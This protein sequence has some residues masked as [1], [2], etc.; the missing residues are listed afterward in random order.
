MHCLFR[1]G[2]GTP[3][4][5]RH[6][7][8]IHRFALRLDKLCDPE[9]FKDALQILP[10]PRAD[11]GAPDPLLAEENI[12]LFPLGRAFD[13]DGWISN[14]RDR[15]LDEAEAAGRDL[16]TANKQ[17]DA[18]TKG[19]KDAL[20]ILRKR[21]I[22]Y[23]AIPGH[24]GLD[25]LVRIFDNLNGRGVELD[26]IDLLRAKAAKENP[27]FSLDGWL[28]KTVDILAERLSD[29]K[30]TIF[31][32][33]TSDSAAKDLR[34]RQR[35]LL[36][37]VGASSDGH[38]G[39]K[40]MRL[41]I[42]DL[43]ATSL[44]QGG[45]RLLKGAEWAGVILADAGF[46]GLRDL[47]Y[48]K[49]FSLAAIAYARRHAQLAS[50]GPQAARWNARMRQALLAA[51]FSGRLGASGEVNLNRL[52]PQVEAFVFDD[53]PFPPDLLAKG[54]PS[55]AA[56]G[57]PV[58]DA[59]RRRLFSGVLR[60]LKPRDLCQGTRIDARA[61]EL[62][63]LFPKDWC[64]RQG[65]NASLRDS[66]WNLTPIL[67]GT[68]SSIGG[69]APKTDRRKQDPQG[70]VAQMVAEQGEAT[71]ADILKSHLVPV[72]DFREERFAEAIAGRRRAMLALL[73]EITGLPLPEDGRSE[74]E[75]KGVP[76]EATHAFR[77][78]AGAVAYARKIQ[79]SRGR[80]VRYALL[81]G[82][83]LVQAGTGLPPRLEALWRSAT[84]DAEPVL[85]EEGG[86]MPR[87]RRRLDGLTAAEIASLAFGQEIQGKAARL[88]PIDGEEE[89]G[90]EETAQ[91]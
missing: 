76:P 48:A 58:R 28:A 4:A 64:D 69:R 70:Y 32:T 51:A 42:K 21:E 63:H 38:D 44:E 37:V 31:A 17:I 36:H 29:G 47:P 55:A 49:M 14:Y 62:H 87:I 86:E 43:G 23:E 74:S 34:D 27:S 71:V 20:D 1:L 11:H 22:C 66:P 12:A 83:V 8:T 33:P 90:E 54:G 35:T 10:W 52:V 19:L 7:G 60:S 46:P 59:A 5:K 68:N 75:D 79:G 89:T 15:R 25:G 16:R 3:Q 65:I 41:T 26:T 84:E 78:P 77:T 80:A 88:Q 13:R 39:K 91:A 2:Y 6:D 45:E 24:V 56:V 73:R 53:A 30:A 85:T 50:G 61:T 82:S 40:T 57:E 18:E 81:P 9:D 67:P 72:E